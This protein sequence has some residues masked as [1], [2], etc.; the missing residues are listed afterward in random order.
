MSHGELG[1]VGCPYEQGHKY[2]MSSINIYNC[3]LTIHDVNNAP[4]IFGPNIVRVRGKT[5]RKK[6]DR[7]MKYYVA[8]PRDFLEMHKYVTLVSDVCFVNNV[9]FLVTMSRGIKFVTVKFISTHTYKQLSKILKRVIKRYTRGYMKVQ[10]I[11]MYTEF[12]K[13]V[14]DMM[15]NV[16]V[17]TSAATK[18][19]T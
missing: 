18:H 13:T 3:P 8:V 11:L 7:V 17:N 16:L 9:A 6:P 2:F 15:D 4:V 5:F 12:D 1:I 19:V 14:D 10:T